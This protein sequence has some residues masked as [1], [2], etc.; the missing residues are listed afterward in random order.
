MDRKHP[1]PNAKPQN[2]D[3][4]PG[5]KADDLRPEAVRAARR[6]QALPRDRVYVF[7]L[8]KRTHEWLLA[9]HEPNGA[10]IEK[11]G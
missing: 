9:L 8:V 7:T 5:V 11:L 10:K 4:R 1:N 3:T 2:G 6:L